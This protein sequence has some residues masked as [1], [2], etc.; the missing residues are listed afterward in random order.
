MTITNHLFCG[1]SK[2]RKENVTAVYNKKSLWVLIC[3]FKQ[4]I[5][6]CISL[7]IKFF[8]YALHFMNI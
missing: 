6:K 2:Q 3:L 7:E 5:L 8:R 4:A 1:K